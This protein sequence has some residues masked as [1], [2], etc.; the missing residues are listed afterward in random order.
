MSGETCGQIKPLIDDY[1]KHLID[2]FDKMED[3]IDMFINKSHETI[4]LVSK[5]EEKVCAIDK[6]NDRN[7]EQH[8]E[9][10]SKLGKVESE[11]DKVAGGIKVVSVVLIPVVLAVV[12]TLVKAFL[13]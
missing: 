4:N 10:Y 2:R 9:F 5:I 1:Q 8:K 13:L 3:K 12:V 6:E 11:N 7:F